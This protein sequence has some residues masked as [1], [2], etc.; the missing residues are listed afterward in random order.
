MG[1]TSVL[2]A[3]RGATEVTL[4]SRVGP[5]NLPGME[6]KLRATAPE[7]PKWW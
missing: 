3:A 1:V 4:H 5:G 2:W 7:L 6:Q